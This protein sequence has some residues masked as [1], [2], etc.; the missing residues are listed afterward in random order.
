[1]GKLAGELE[2]YGVKMQIKNVLFD[3][4]DTLVQ[5]SAHYSQD[6]CLARLVKSL[7]QNGIS[8]SFEDCKKAYETTYKKILARNSVRETTY[9]VVVS[10]VLAL[11]GFPLKPTD[12]ATVEAA[13][14]F[15]NCWVETRIMEESVPSVL[16]TLKARYSL[17]VVSNIAYAP[18]VSR[19][20]DRFGV[21]DCFKAII[22]SA[23]VGWRKPSPRIF[24]SALRTMGISAQETVYVGDELDHDVEGAGKVGMRTVLLKRTSTDMNA[25]S[26]KPDATI[27]EWKQLPSALKSIERL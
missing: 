4:G 15:M 19:T 14:A 27:Q 17:G 3:F 22:V 26:A 12:K 8:V 9:D 24:R 2:E 21:T 5:A 23:D 10:H 6:A 25:S 1:M 13:E 18:A 16:R 20:L 7:A 11:C